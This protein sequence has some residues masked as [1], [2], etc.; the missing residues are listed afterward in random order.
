MTPSPRL[1]LPL[2]FVSAAALFGQP[3]APADNTTV[4]TINGE[5]VAADEYTLVMNRQVGP[6]YSLFKQTRN[7]DDH[8]GYWSPASGPDGPLAKLRELTLAE[9]VRI[10]ICQ[11]QAKARGLVK[12]MDFASFRT[13]YEQEN[14]RR[15]AAKA[16]GEVV[17]GPPQYRLT[18]YYYI[19]LGDLAYKLEL[20]MAKELEPTVAAGA[21]ETLL[22]SHE[23]EFKPLSPG[24]ARRRAVVVL[25]TRAT[26]QK[27]Q[28]LR[29]SAVTDVRDD[30][31][32]RLFPR[33]DDPFTN[34]APVEKT[35]T[36]R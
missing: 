1:L 30:L 16:R 31:L 34:L 29:A 3:S 6:V 4:L 20:A 15:L 32:A 21:I 11:S 8:V 36:T 33:S 19:L 10:K 2:L 22:A 13:A 35:P 12:N 28:G 5:P 7:L 27:L 14:A 17:Y 18:S 24:D 26:R 9:L 25:S 23:E